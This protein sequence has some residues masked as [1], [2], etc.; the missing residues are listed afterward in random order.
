MLK[1]LALSSFDL[2]HSFIVFQHIPI[3]RGEVILRELIDLI[4]DGGVGA[5][6]FTFSDPRSALRRIL[7]ASCPRARL[8]DGLLN[9]IQHRPFSSPRMQ[10]NS[11]SMNRIFKSCSMRIVRICTSSSRTIAAF[12]AP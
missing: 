11:Y 6:H 1:P 7:K 3:A 2:V 8:M 10:V 5:I 12:A 4:A 9:L